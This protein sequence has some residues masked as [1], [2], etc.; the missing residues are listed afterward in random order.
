MMD[1]FS[2][3]SISQTLEFSTVVKLAAAQDLQKTLSK[4]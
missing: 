3:I 4:L 2:W 1:D